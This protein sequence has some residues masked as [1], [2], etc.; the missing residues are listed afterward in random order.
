MNKFRIK[1]MY[2]EYNVYVCLKC[3]GDFTS[4]CLRGEGWKFCPLCGT[5]WDGEFT[6][7]NPRYTLP[8]K[9]DWR[10]PGYKTDQKTGEFCQS[11]KPRLIIEYGAVVTQ[12][13]HRDMF[14]VI[15]CTPFIRW[16][17]LMH[18]TI[19]GLYSGGESS[20]FVGI[21]KAFK[22]YIADG[23]YEML[24]LRFLSGTESKVIKTWSK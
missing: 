16:G 17:L 1:S 13:L 14:C 5:R 15:P 4:N 9:Y 22:K 18:S 24:R 19:G 2:D 6:K 11:D 12:V 8:N 10:E 20:I 3:K 21:Y 7:R 23:R